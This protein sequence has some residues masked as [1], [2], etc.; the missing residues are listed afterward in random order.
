MLRRGRPRGASD[1]RGT[2]RPRRRRARGGGGFGGVRGG[3][4]RAARRGG[5]APHHRPDRP[6]GAVEEH[7]AGDA[8]LRGAADH[9][10]R[11][12]GRGR[13]HRVRLSEPARAGGVSRLRSRCRAHGRTHQPRVRRRAGPGGLDAHFAVGRGRPGPLA[14]RPDVVGCAA[15]Q[16]CARRAQPGGQGRLPAQYR[17]RRA[18]ALPR[19][20]RVGGARAGRW[21]RARDQP[22]RRVGDG[23]GAPCRPCDECGRTHGEGDGAAPGG[24]G[25]DGG[26]LVGRPAGGRADF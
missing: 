11:V 2:A 24:A 1:V 16:P 23:R 25:P 18:R 19:G 20:W 6:H 12:A 10:P 8:R 7:R 13:P 4:R 5:W 17:R 26:G 3:G 22:L 15:G 14:G 21:R 9:P